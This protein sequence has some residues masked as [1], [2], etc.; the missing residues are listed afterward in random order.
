MTLELEGA[1]EVDV[2]K[3][4]MNSLNVFG[5][6]SILDQRVVARCSVIRVLVR[7]SESLER[8]W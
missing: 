1:L 4:L 6:S 5:Q 3:I 7:V 8:Q 2:T